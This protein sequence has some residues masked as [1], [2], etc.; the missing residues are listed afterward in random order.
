LPNCPEIDTEQPTPVDSAGCV[1]R[2][3]RLEFFFLQGTEVV[4]RVALAKEATP[5]FL[6]SMKELQ[7][8]LVNS[9]AIANPD[10]STRDP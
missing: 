9:G 8:F 5:G 6:L 4:V 3:G 7:Q 2:D 10:E 1:F